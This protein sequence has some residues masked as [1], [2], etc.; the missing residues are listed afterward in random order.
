MKDDIQVSVY[1]RIADGTLRSEMEIEYVL[2]D[3]LL[4]RRHVESQ[5]NEINRFIA[6]LEGHGNE[7]VSEKTRA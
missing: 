7:P 6:I 2:N 5:L 1:D 3:M 4:R